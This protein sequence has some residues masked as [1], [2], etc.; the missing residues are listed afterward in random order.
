MIKS[1]SLMASLVLVTGIASAVALAPQ[2]GEDFQSLPPDPAV[3]EQQLAAAHHSMAAAI[4][5]AEATVGGK[6]LAAEA[7]F[8]DGGVK[9]EILVGVDGGIRRAVVDGTTGE[10]SAARIGIAEALELAKSEVDGLVSSVQTNL[11][12][13]PPTIEIVTYRDHKAHRIVVDAALGM[14][15]FTEPVPRFPGEPVSGDWIE[16]PTGLKYFDIVEGTGAMPSGPQSQVRVHYTGW[17]TNGTKFD[18]S[19]DR[20]QPATF[21]LGRVIP[22]WTEG[23]GSMRVGGKRKLIIPYTI[24]YGEQGSPPRIPPRATLIFDVELIEVVG[25]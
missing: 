2:G 16:T 19:V 21:P 8:V 11:G 10:V 15:L 1:L 4:A 13:D 17:L 22:G 18:S 14:I 20:G 24:A 9:Y 6:A 7:S 23:V 25:E 3:A 12:G 5:K